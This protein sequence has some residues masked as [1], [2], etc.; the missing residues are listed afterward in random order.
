MRGM[1]CSLVILAVLSG[2]CCAVVDPTPVYYDE[3]WGNPWTSAVEI[4]AYF[5]LPIDAEFSNTIA[6]QEGGTRLVIAGGT[7]TII[8]RDGNILTVLTA[9]H[10]IKGARDYWVEARDND[11]KT[12]IAQGYDVKYS[13]D[14]D[15]CIFFIK[16]QQIA[17]IKKVARLANDMPVPGARLDVVGNAWGMG[18]RWMTPGP[19]ANDLP[20]LASGILVYRGGYHSYPGCSGAGVWHDGKVVGVV[21]MVLVIPFS[22]KLQ[23]PM[24]DMGLFVG[25]E[26]VHQL[27]RK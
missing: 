17:R 18:L 23:V 27:L 1:I 13:K 5:R 6:L 3:A 14:S 9:R 22:E 2:V 16:S 10:V 8:G 25:V 15:V 26:W 4:E 11:G 19:L 21:S 12:F 7:G 24:G 20:R